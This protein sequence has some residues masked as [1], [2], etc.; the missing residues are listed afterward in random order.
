MTDA[1]GVA[2]PIDSTHPSAAEASARVALLARAHASVV[3]ADWS[4]LPQVLA[5][6][7]PRG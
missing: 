4:S 2:P 3:T 1:A 7:A 6:V 5:M